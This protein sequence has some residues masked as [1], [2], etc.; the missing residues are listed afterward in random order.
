MRARGGIRGRPAPAGNVE[1]GYMV[2]VAPCPARR[3]P[4]R[5]SDYPRTSRTGAPSGVA[6]S[7]CSSCES[8]R[9]TPCT[10]V[11]CR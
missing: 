4:R 5:A 3:T 2:R 9:R 8:G 1:S 6:M 10:A 11:R 7:T